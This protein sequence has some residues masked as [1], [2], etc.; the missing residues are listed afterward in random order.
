METIRYYVLRFDEYNVEIG[1]ADVCWDCWL[2]KNNYGVKSYMF[3]LP[4]TNTTL[5]QCV[6]IVRANAP[7]YI[8][9]YRKEY[10]E[11]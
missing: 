5:E 2:Y 1:A 7:E 3:G 10:E 9:T 11:E 6:E 8:E 4:R